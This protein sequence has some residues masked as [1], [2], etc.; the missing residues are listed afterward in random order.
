MSVNLPAGGWIIIPNSHAEGPVF[1]D[2]Q[3]AKFAHLNLAQKVVGLKGEWQSKSD[4]IR[5]FAIYATIQELRQP[6][7]PDFSATPDRYPIAQKGPSDKAD[8]HSWA[9]STAPVH[10]WQEEPASDAECPMRA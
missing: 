8:R 7:D 2:L 10:T 1:A 5:T 9:S 3:G 6:V 4:G